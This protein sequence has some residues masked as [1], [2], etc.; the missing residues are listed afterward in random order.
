VMNSDG[1]FHYVPL[2]PLAILVAF[3][4]AALA[5]RVPRTALLVVAV[6]CI[7][8][9]AAAITARPSDE[10]AS[11]RRQLADALAGIGGAIDRSPPGTTVR[12]PNR[13]FPPVGM[14]IVFPGWAALFTIYHPDDAVDGRRVVFVEPNPAVI[15]FGRKG[16]RSR[17]LLVSP[18]P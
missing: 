1:R 18:Q 7:V 9:V 8:A 12:I 13:V 5:A 16:R 14:Q 4:I 10:C 2:I 11:S 17:T 15:D 6:W 3:P